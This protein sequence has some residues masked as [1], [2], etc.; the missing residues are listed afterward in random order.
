MYT[1]N[2][3]VMLGILLALT[4]CGSLGA[5]TMYVQTNLTS[6]IPGLAANTDPN[7]KNPWGVSFATTSPFWVSDQA[8][9]KATLYNAAGVP[10]G[11]V[12]STPG[13][14]TGQVFN[15]TSGFTIGSSGPANF[16]FST[17]SGNIEAWNGA[18]G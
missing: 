10:Q 1:H 4:V 5:A 11:L 7:L 18:Q 14:P 6:D 3:R 12:V 13:G 16:I 9:G 15:P 2:N 17:L 8:T